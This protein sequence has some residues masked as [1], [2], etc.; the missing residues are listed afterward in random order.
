M[1]TV[2]D[3]IDVLNNVEDKTLPITA[4]IVEYADRREIDLDIDESI[5]VTVELN[6]I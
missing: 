2:Q 5:E 3:L 1:V 4:Y 6:I